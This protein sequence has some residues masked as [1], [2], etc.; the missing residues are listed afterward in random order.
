MLSIEDAKRIMAAGLGRAELEFVTSVTAP[1]YWVI[2]AA[3]GGG[4]LQAR[5]GSAFF[6][7]AGAGVF[8]LTAA[9]HP[10]HAEGA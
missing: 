3:D 1:L 6:L 2:P 5:N 4:R 10:G 7:D 9:C 8:G